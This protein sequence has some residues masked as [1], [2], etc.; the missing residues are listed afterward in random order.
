MFLWPQCVAF[1][2]RFPQLATEN[3]VKQQQQL[4]T[5]EINLS[6]EVFLPIA[7]VTDMM[8]LVIP[9]YDVTLN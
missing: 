8:V 2:T 3:F 7:Y 9:L 1:T 6:H 5:C 4:G